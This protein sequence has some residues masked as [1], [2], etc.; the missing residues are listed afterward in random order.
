[1][2][3]VAIEPVAWSSLRGFFEEYGCALIGD[4]VLRWYQE[5]WGAVA[6]WGIT[7][8]SC[9]RYEDYETPSRLQALCLLHMYLGMYQQQMSGELAEDF[10]GLYSLGL[11]VDELHIN[12]GDL[13]RALYAE[14]LIGMDDVRSVLLEW[15]EHDLV[16]EIAAEDWPWDKIQKK[17]EQFLDDMADSLMEMFGWGAVEELIKVDNSL[18][19]DA[20]SEHYGGDV[21]MFAAIWN[22]RRE[23]DQVESVD[24]VVNSNVSGEKLAAWEYA[25]SGMTDWNAAL[26]SWE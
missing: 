1:M 8:L 5:S 16:R 4:T 6:R 20:I 18:L 22:S 7:K 11:M 17:G 12:R 26:S 3:V 21:D 24:D 9:S 23:L 10:D 13:L 15:E 14:E 25:R 19:Y 2:R